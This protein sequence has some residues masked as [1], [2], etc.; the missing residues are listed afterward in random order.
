MS[1]IE[2]FKKTCKEAV[3]QCKISLSYFDFARFRISKSLVESFNLKPKESQAGIHGLNRV[4]IAYQALKEA[5]VTHMHVSLVYRDYQLIRLAK[6]VKW[7]SQTALII[8]F[9]TYLLLFALQAF[10]EI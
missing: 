2:E 9:S 4:L 5:H 6:L 10:Y 7:I 8:N 3:G 1:S